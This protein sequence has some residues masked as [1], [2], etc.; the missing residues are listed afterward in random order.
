[1]ADETTA[2]S[3]NFEANGD[4]PESY[5]LART[6]GANSIRALVSSALQTSTLRD[7]ASRVRRSDRNQ[8][9]TD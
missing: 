2:N 9:K 3:S 6:R 8:D 7:Y 1:M 5:G 4:Y